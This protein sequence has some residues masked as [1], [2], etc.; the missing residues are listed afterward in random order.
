MKNILNLK[1]IAALIVL[2]SLSQETLANVRRIPTRIDQGNVSDDFQRGRRKRPANDDSV[3]NPGVR[4]KRPTH[5]GSG[6]PQG[7]VSTTISSDNKALS[8]LFDQY[9]AEAGGPSQA[10]IQR[11]NCL[12]V[13]PFEVP[14]GLQASIVQLDYR[15]YNFIPAH[16]KT[17]LTATYHFSDLKIGK[18]YGRKI[19]RKIQFKGPLDEDYLISS[20]V[21]RHQVWSRCGR[22]FN[23]HIDTDVTAKTNSQLD[24]VM[25]V[26]DSVDAGANEKVEYFLKWRRCRHQNEMGPDERRPPNRRRPG[27]RPSTHRPRR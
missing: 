5:G 2:I 15:G 23:L 25:S 4:M 19:K 13:I 6:C 20:Q 12:I 21:H 3:F 8:I 14:P 9:I 16:G 10:K 7:S 18:T 1:L 26:V 22:D 24:D 17:R 27:R 11:K